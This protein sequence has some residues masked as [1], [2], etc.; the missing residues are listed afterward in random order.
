MGSGAISRFRFQHD[1][2]KHEKPVPILLDVPIDVRGLLRQPGLQR[3]GP[4]QRLADN[5]AN[6]SGWMGKD[7]GKQ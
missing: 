7:N 4:I 2:G 1:F 3:K 5:P 6:I